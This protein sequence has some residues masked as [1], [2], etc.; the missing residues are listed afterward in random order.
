MA[1]GTKELKDRAA[2]LARHPRARIIA[3][4]FV[5]VTIIVG[6]LGS[7]AAPPL[8]RGK[9]AS[10]LSE[11]LHRAVTIEQIRIN[12][13]AMTVAVRGFLM[14][15]RQGTATAVS[16]DELRLN[17]ELQSLF[18]WGLVIKE[19]RLVRPYVNLVRDENLKY[20][21]QDLI[22]EFTK[23]PPGPTPRFALKN[24][25]IVDGKVDSIG[26]GLAESRGPSAESPEVIDCTG[27]VVSPG[28]G[29]R[30]GRVW[31]RAG[32][33][34]GHHR[35]SADHRKRL[36]ERVGSSVGPD[37]PSSPTPTPGV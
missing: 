34:R 36:G 15:E 23:G 33:I 26:R 25:E 19:L 17:L 12:P 31:S 35:L 2:E 4:W 10:V 3:L 37:L 27:L 13:Y 11:K 32:H 24:I 18:R 6:V 21:Y 9:L 28:G 8:L 29:R 16:F 20:N 30:D 22:D 7:L 5:A 14:K 1:P